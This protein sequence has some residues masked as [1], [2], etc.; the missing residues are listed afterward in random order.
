MSKKEQA[1]TRADDQL[2][3]IAYPF[4]GVD[5]RKI[6][7]QDFGKFLTVTTFLPPNSFG[8]MIKTAL[9]EYS[10]LRFPNQELTEDEEPENLI[11]HLYFSRQLFP[12]E[13]NEIFTIGLRSLHFLQVYSDIETQEAVVTIAPPLIK[14]AAMQ[15]DTN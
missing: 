11:Q 7:R 5:L 14:L 1:F 2:Y 8:G 15:N 3:N 9:E 12:E 4:C 10:G 6:K 13:E